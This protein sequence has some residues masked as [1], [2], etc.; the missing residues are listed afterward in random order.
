MVATV[1]VIID[2]HDHISGPTVR[3]FEDTDQAVSWAQYARGCGCQGEV[4]GVFDD[5]G[6]EV[7]FATPDAGDSP[8]AHSATK[9]EWQKYADAHGVKYPSDATK[10]QIIKLVEGNQ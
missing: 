9:S 8:P 10:D 7:G 1:H 5:E 3:R 2:Q 4:V 6:N